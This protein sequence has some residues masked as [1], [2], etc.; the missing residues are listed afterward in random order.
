MHRRATILTSTAVLALLAGCGGTPAADGGGSAAAQSE[1]AASKAPAKVA[2]ADCLVG[3][4]KV[5]ASSLGDLMESAAEAMGATAPEITYSG[6]S[7]TTFAK[8]GTFT[9][10]VNLKW[11]SK[12][13]MDGTVQDALRAATGAQK[14]TWKVD[15]VTLTSTVTEDGVKATDSEKVG[16]VEQPASDTP[17]SIVDGLLPTTPMS[18]TCDATTFTLTKAPGATTASASAPA[19]A[20]L[21]FKRA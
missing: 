4:W 6:S 3:S 18:A 21:K 20:E 15:G 16:G 17:A 2:L 1:P 5:D 7:T 9:T 8:D 12:A 19:R 11:D 10:D 13:T 14:G